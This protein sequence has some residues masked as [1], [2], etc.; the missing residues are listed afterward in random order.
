MS[1]VKQEESFLPATEIQV[2]HICQCCH[3]GER[4]EYLVHPAETAKSQ[5]TPP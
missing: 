4:K 3:Q 5:D 1:T 2:V